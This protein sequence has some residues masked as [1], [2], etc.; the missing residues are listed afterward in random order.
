LCALASDFV[1]TALSRKEI[2]EPP[3]RIEVRMTNQSGGF[4]DLTDEPDRDQGFDVM[5]QRRRRDLELFLEAANRHARMTR[6]DQGPVDLKPCSI[7]QGFEARRRIVDLHGGQN[8]LP[9]GGSQ[10][11]FLE[12]SK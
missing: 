5:R 2:N 12:Y 7:T 6:P 11:V 1:G 3:H 9:H 10:T 4:P 8:A